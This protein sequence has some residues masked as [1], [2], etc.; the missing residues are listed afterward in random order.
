MTEQ[1]GEEQ[2]PS[3]CHNTAG[4]RSLHAATEQRKER[5]EVVAYVTTQQQ[6]EV[7][8]P[9]HVCCS[10]SALGTH[11]GQCV[12]CAGHTHRAELVLRWAHTQ[13]SV[14]SALGTRTGQCLFCAGH[15][16]MTVC[17]LHWAHTYGRILM[18]PCSKALAQQHTC[19]VRLSFV[20]QRLI[21][22]RRVLKVA[23]ADLMAEGAQNGRG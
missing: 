12:F 8:L 23:E 18:R 14:C 20:W 13:G 6:A 5:S 16:H 17:V 7:L 22:R 9:S 1:E 2:G 10:C 19:E 11:T 4:G 3:K 21:V 15:T